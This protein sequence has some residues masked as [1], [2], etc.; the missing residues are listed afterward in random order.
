MWNSNYHTAN[1]EASCALRSELYDRVIQVVPN[2][3]FLY[4]IHLFKDFCW[5][6]LI[7]QRQWYRAEEVGAPSK[8]VRISNVK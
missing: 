8:T 3:V 6:S 4:E 5:K 1:G 2:Y 7:K